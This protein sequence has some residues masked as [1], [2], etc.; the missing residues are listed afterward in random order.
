MMDPIQLQ[1]MQETSLSGARDMMS[2]RYSP[3]GGGMSEFSATANQYGLPIT[4][5]PL[6]DIQPLAPL[7]LSQYGVFGSLA[8][9]AGNT[10]LNTAF[11]NQ[12]L[13]ATGNAGSYLQAQRT[14]DHK[15]NS[16]AVSMAIA[17]QDS[18]G[19]YRTIRGAAAL[20]G[21]P[22]N[23]DQQQAARNLS[24][25]AAGF[26]PTLAAISPDFAD[27]VSGER[28][29]VQAM[30]SQMMEANRYRVDPITGRMGFGA[31][32][33]TDMVN[34]VFSTMFADDN[35]ARMRGLR[36]GDVGQ[37]YR[38]LTPEGLV[39]PT[40]GLRERTIRSLQ[41]VREEGTDL[42]QVAK[43]QGV[44][45]TP[46][47]NLESLSN[48]ELAKLRQSPGVKKE[49]TKADTRQV[50]DQLQSY[51]A[52]LSAMREVFGENGNPNAPMPLLINSLKALTSGQMQ[53]FDASQLNSI[54]RDMQAMGQLSGKSV[55]QMLAMNRDASLSNG[56][57]VGANYG[58]HF[59]PAAVNV[60]V[61][62]GMAFQERGA[63]TGFGALNR[64]QA[65]QASM[66]MFSRGLG[67]EM[68]NALGALSRIEEA[69]GFSENAAGRE[70]R[71]VLAA[72]DL[73]AESYTFIGDDGQAVTRKVPNRENDFRRIV[74]EGAIDGM[75]VSDFNQM[76]GNKTSNLR[77]LSTN[78]E[79]QMAAMR[80]Q[81][82]EI[83]RLAARQTANTL[84][85]NSQIA[86]QFTSRADQSRVATALGQAANTAADEL[87]L[88]QLQDPKQR[89][90]IIADALQVEA[91]NQGMELDDRE[92]LNMAAA[93][94]GAR[95]TTLLAYT[96]M[97]ATGFAQVNSKKMREGRSEHQ[98][99]VAARSG[100][101]QAMSG[102][103]PR[104]T[105]VQRL[106]TAIQ[107]Q[108]DRGET[109]DLSSLLGDM[110]ATDLGDASAKLTPLLSDIRTREQQIKE[111]TAELDGAPPERLSQLTAEIQK[112]NAELEA[113][114]AETHQVADKLGMTEQENTFNAED[115]SRGQTASRE[116]DYLNRVSQAR[117][118]AAVGPVSDTERKAAGQTK[119]SQQ[120]LAVL[121]ERD[122][123]NQLAEAD[124]MGGR[125]A[126]SA[127]ELRKQIEKE[128]R[129]DPA[130]NQFGRKKTEQ[131]LQEEIQ[132]RFD[133]EED[134][135]M[136]DEAKAIYDKAI[137]TGATDEHARTKVRDTL[138]DTTASVSQLAEFRRQGL[139]DGTTV[140]ALASQEERDAVIRARRSER[141]VLPTG[142][143]VETRVDQLRDQGVGQAKKTVDEVQQLDAAAKKL[144][145]KGE[146]DLEIAAEDSLLAEN[147]LRVLGALGEKE[148]LLDD[149][150][151]ASS[152]PDELRAQLAAAKP[153]ERTA[154][155]M[156]YLDR[157]RQ[158]QFYGKDEEE[159]EAKRKEALRRVGT[160][161]GRQTSRDVDRNL[162]S[163]REVR[164]EYLADNGAVT[165]GGALGLVAV[166]R[167]QRA[168]ADMQVLANRYFKGNVGEMLSSGGLAMTE[169][170]KKRAAEDLEKLSPEEQEKV[171]ARL[172]VAGQDIAADA[173]LTESNYRHYVSL[174]GQDAKQAMVDA[175]KDLAGAANQSY[176]N[177]LKP[178]DETKAKAAQLFGGNA[179]D[180]QAVGLQALESAAMLKG[181]KLDDSGL[182]L[183][184]MADK[185]AAGEKIDTSQLSAEN[186][187]LVETA[188]GMQGLSGLSKEQLDAVQSLSRMESADVSAEAKKLGISEEDYRKMVTG[189]QAVDPKLRVG[190][191]A[192]E[193]R[194]AKQEN[195]TLTRSKVA[196]DKAEA[197]AKS[198]KL[199]PAAAR[200]LKDKRAGVN[201][202]EKRKADRMRAA[203]LDISNPDDVAIYH[204][205]LENQ[206]QVDL[207]ERRRAAYAEAT[208]TAEKSGMSED[209]IDSSKGLV[210]KLDK[211]GEERSQ[212]YRDRD[213]GDDA[214]N[215]IANAFEGDKQL[216]KE[217]RA[218]LKADLDVGGESAAQNKRM[219][220][221]VL[222]QVSK[223]DSAQFDSGMT[224]IQK[225]DQLHDEFA[226]AK[227]GDQRK[228]MA[229][230]YNLSEDALGRMMAQT[231]FL[232][233]AGKDENGQDK[234]LT[235]ERL[236][237]GLQ[238][239]GDR[240]IEDD[241]KQQEERTVRLTGTLEVRGDITGTATVGDV[242]GQYGPR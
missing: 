180:E 173:E 239:V 213:L 156:A 84:V 68:A 149:P 218:K 4:G 165:R 18:E 32:A 136:S 46:D 59:N 40:G 191:S 148:S 30:A 88:S 163:L 65:E 96:G 28:G 208:E 19:I 206:G 122:R 147:Q 87:E 188:Q 45:M 36:A 60:G 124:S 121:A 109:A 113:K 164:K 99:S 231:E 106:F 3:S 155:A 238:E 17:A 13:L 181:T 75:N 117:A 222:T 237:E 119:L 201:K 44:E 127:T 140:D 71:A 58:V 143:E 15:N 64:E 137:D 42:S 199:G 33:N 110:F 217:Q 214:V 216:T 182:D 76:L 141:T 240:N 9:M 232:D 210:D 51:V 77:A 118:I 72:A 236:V 31:A 98:A 228:A 24:A 145:A 196:L 94:F 73:G 38:Q 161:E 104:G 62:T 126:M 172:R 48:T 162:A 56:A 112:M 100:L 220:A 37:M 223:L 16:K 61:T 192:Q 212:A 204:S 175:N 178:T 154:V 187:E 150:A 79:R 83:N 103:G 177:M 144:Y 53:K 198:G 224:N 233:V 197:D 39:G 146:R 20:A 215:V 43:L 78:E 183:K 174:Q 203:G 169:E 225:L 97:D 82:A 50:T 159:V 176:A 230:K 52:S 132:K 108:G 200:A 93:S 209:D 116:L 69:G 133:A 107:E 139:G 190:N 131:Q 57:I 89:N 63:T 202:L 67:S 35:M 10:M 27:A 91:A 86:K 7:G 221:N 80:Q 47:Q 23:R 70:M 185:I 207:L 158:E 81:P 226:E 125:K 186:K 120:D 11:Q 95:E 5:N 241:V 111:K 235:Q 1:L 171:R 160:A 168:E 74:N 6:P 195:D 12:G 205:R 92:A 66:S 101:N 90:R 29:S 26:M 194:E 211:L 134:T 227:T 153:E 234:M 128:V 193:L 189:E 114:V 123:K 229:K 115:A 157:Q 14:R 129:N 142:E 219:V 25:T 170:G 102:L 34:E 167:S 179:T 2:G 135:V 8:E 166:E 22:F 85:G 55:D 54:V 138:R 49:L 130:N 105:M 242:T 152:M 41:R 151:K 21:M 184:T